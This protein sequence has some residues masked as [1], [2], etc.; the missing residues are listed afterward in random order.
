MYIMISILTKLFDIRLLTSFRT[1][2]HVARALKARTCEEVNHMI[3]RV[4]N[5]E[6]LLLTSTY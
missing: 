6:F 5:W 2:S 3:T 1:I 4:L